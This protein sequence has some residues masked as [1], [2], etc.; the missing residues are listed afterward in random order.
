MDQYKHRKSR[1]GTITFIGDGGHNAP[2]LLS[3][4]DIKR[5]NEKYPIS[6]YYLGNQQSDYNL[7]CSY[8]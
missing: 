8:F 4:K 7:F 2:A 5:L 1:L 3:P 6:S